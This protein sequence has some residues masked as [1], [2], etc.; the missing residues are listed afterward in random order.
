MSALLSCSYWPPSHWAALGAVL[1]V[2]LAKWCLLTCLLHCCS[3]NCTRNCI[4]P[5]CGVVM[6]QS[7]CG[8]YGAGVPLLPPVVPHHVDG[9]AVGPSQNRVLRAA[10]FKTLHKRWAG[11]VQV[12]FTD[13][14]RSSKLPLQAVFSASDCPDNGFCFARCLLYGERRVAS[15]LGYA[16][17]STWLPSCVDA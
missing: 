5:G 17:G 12:S 11:V 13:I 16:E 2:G 6:P 8:Q 3:R 1:G 7:P 10:T 14:R 15:G 9:A 4:P